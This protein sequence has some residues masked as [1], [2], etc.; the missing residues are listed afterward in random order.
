MKHLA[1]IQTEF[2]KQARDW[3]EFS[4]EE[5]KDYLKRHP[6][7]KRRITAKPD[8]KHSDS[9]RENEALKDLLSNTNKA[10]ILYFSDLGNRY[11]KN[12]KDI[13]N[14]FC[15]LWAITVQHI[16]SNAELCYDG[17]TNHSFIKINDKFYDAQEL[18]GVEDWRDLPILKRYW[19][20]NLKQSADA[21]E[22]D[23][24]FELR[25]YEPKKMSDKTMSY[26]ELISQYHK[27]SAQVEEIINKI[28]GY[29]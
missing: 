20:E 15:W 27:N 19:P 6:K 24:S 1:I 4:L 29:F 12:I 10:L 25:F 13:N 11:Y 22:L 9:N 5:Q 2:L 17:T 26:N 23:K 18:N 28:K 21:G 8:T 16:V 7:T 14:G 3:D